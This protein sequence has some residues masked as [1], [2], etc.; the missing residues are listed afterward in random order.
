V[1]HPHARC[2]SAGLP[3]AAG[4]R[5]APPRGARLSGTRG[6][7]RRQELHRRHRRPLRIAADRRAAAHRR[8]HLSARAQRCRHPPAWRP[9]GLFRAAM[10][11]FRRGRNLRPAGIDLAGR[12]PGLSGHRGSALPLSAA[13]AGHAT[14]RDDGDNGRSDRRQSRASFVFLAAAGPD[15]PTASV[16]D[17]RAAR[18]SVRRGDAAEQRNPRGRG[19]TRGFRRAPRDGR[20]HAPI[21]HGVRV[22]CRRGSATARGDGGR[23]RSAPAP[24]PAHHRTLPDLLRRLLH[25]ARRPR[26]RRHAVR[27]VRGFLPGADP[28]P[29]CAEPALLPI[30]RAAAR[31]I[32][33]ASDRVLLH[34][35]NSPAAPDRPCGGQSARECFC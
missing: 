23:A 34:E 28:L 35:R 8:A 27:P 4:G 11:D 13:G 20:G 12:R 7:S 1:Q 33:S 6:V 3:R 31:G 25:R 10:A 18:R 19:H 17:C 26:P 15:D 30:R 32:V 29:R 24:R 2:G 22:R 21:R 16:P 14:D 5:R 9:G